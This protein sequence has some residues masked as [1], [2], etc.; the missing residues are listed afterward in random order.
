MAGAGGV[1]PTLNSVTL[2][3]LPQNSPPVLKTINVITQAAA[4]TQAAVK[5]SGSTSALQRD[6]HR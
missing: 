2:A 3:Y 1:T 6:R 4:I 5:S